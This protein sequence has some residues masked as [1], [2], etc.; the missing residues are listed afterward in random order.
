M[1]IS[2]Q[3][4]A[5]TC[6][7]LYR[8]S[9]DCLISTSHFVY[10]GKNDRISLLN[11]CAAISGAEIFYWRSG[12]PQIWFQRFIFKVPEYLS[13]RYTGLSTQWHSRT[14]ELEYTKGPMRESH[15]EGIDPG[16]QLSQFVGHGYLIFHHFVQII[17]ISSNRAKSTSPKSSPSAFATKLNFLDKLIE[18]KQSSHY[19]DPVVDTIMLTMMTNRGYQRNWTIQSDR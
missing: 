12:N 2:H 10:I 11:Q 7:T 17:P 4:G 19:S 18:M 14:R 5:V 9:G 6:T 3:G 16:R 13:N 8:R 15:L 1:T